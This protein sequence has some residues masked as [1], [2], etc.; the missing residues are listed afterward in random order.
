MDTAMLQTNGNQSRP[1]DFSLRKLLTLLTSAVALLLIIGNAFVWISHGELQTAEAEKQRLLN[2]SLAFKN[3]RY[4]VVQIQQFLTDASAVGED[5]Y[6]EALTEK[7]AAHNELASLLAIMPELKIEIREADKSVDTLYATGERMANAYFHQGRDAGNLIMKAPQ[8]G[9]DAASEILAT[10]LNQLA[11]KLEQQ[12]RAA[13][14]QQNTMQGQMFTVSATVAGLALLLIVFANL[15]LTTKVSEFVFIRIAAAHPRFPEPRALASW[16][17]VGGL[18][19]T[20][21][22]C[23]HQ[24]PPSPWQRHHRPLPLSSYP[25]RR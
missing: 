3:V 9:F 5:D 8:D 25:K 6:S 4:L 7:N 17:Q 1:Q 16:R 18:A 20:S 10:T 2:A 14:E 22:L 24:W 13:S 21:I 15:W 19:K 12:V 23:G 11:G